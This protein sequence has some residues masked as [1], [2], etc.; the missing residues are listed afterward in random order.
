MPTVQDVLHAD[1]HEVAHSRQLVVFSDF[2]ILGL[3]MVAICLFMNGSS[4]YYNRKNLGTSCAEIIAP[5][6]RRQFLSMFQPVLNQLSHSINLTGIFYNIWPGLVN[7][8]KPVSTRRACILFYLPGTADECIMIP[9]P[10]GYDQRSL[11][12]A[13]LQRRLAARE[14]P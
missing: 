10:A 7:Y 6:T 12:S 13:A 3:M 8:V 14:A 5:A 11:V 9:R 1:W 2:F 4:P